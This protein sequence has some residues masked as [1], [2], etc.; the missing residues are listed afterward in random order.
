MIVPE[1]QARTGF[2]AFCTS[3][4]SR[5]V[6]FWDIKPVYIGSISITCHIFPLVCWAIEN[7]VK[8]ITC[9]KCLYP[10]VAHGRYF[11]FFLKLG[12]TSFG[13]Q[14]AHLGYFREEFVV[15]RRWLSDRTYADLVSLCQF[16]PGPASSQVGMALGLSRAGYAGA[17]AAWAGFTLPSAIALILFALGI[18]SYGEAIDH[19]WTATRVEGGCGSCSGPGCLGHGAQSLP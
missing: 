2:F 11:L 9:R 19:P 4:V 18:A 13:G 6:D 5:Q 7:I 1:G 15:K 17:F 12:L 3:G 16:L 10:T 14:V 8:R